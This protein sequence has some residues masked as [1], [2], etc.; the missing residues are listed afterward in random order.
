[1]TSPDDKIG[2]SKDALYTVVPRSLRIFSA[3]GYLYV[4]GYLN[5]HIRGR[6]VPDNCDARAIGASA[7]VR[8]QQNGGEVSERQKIEISD[9][10]YLAHEL[11]FDPGASR[12][13]AGL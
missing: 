1:M 4:Q 3:A 13:Y 11:G 7:S 2:I 5:V 9:R 10:L 6:S 12:K 8:G